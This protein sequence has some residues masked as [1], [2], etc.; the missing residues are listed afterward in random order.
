MVTP[1]LNPLE[2]F[3]AEGADAEWLAFLGGGVDFEPAPHSSGIGEGGLQ[4]LHSM[5]KTAF[6]D[7]VAGHC[8]SDKELTWA[9]SLIDEST[10]DEGIAK[11]AMD[12]ADEPQTV[13]DFVFGHAGR[14]IYPEDL[15]ELAKLAFI[16]ELHDICG[17]DAGLVKEALALVDDELF[18]VAVASGALGLEKVAFKIP[19]L[20]TGKAVMNV[21]RQM[22]GSAS[23]KIGN[24]LVASGSAAREGAIR[25][26]ERLQSAGKKMQL[27]PDDWVQ[28]ASGRVQQQRGAHRAASL[29]PRSTPLDKVTGRG[30][31]R[32]RLGRRMQR[33]GAG[34]KDLARARNPLTPAP[35][36]L[37]AQRTATEALNPKGVAARMAAAPKP[38]PTGQPSAEELKALVAAGGDGV[39]SVAAK[40][41]SAVAPGGALSAGEAASLESLT[42]D[43]AKAQ[44]AA[45]AKAEAD[46]AAKAQAA[47]AAKAEADAAAK[48][49]AA[50][51]A[52]AEADAAAKLKA[53]GGGEGSKGTAKGTWESA[54]EWFTNATPMQKLLVGGGGLVGAEAALD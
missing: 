9:L 16:H 6:V 23:S 53:A 48:A 28:R 49:Q 47:A 36:A 20:S 17:G 37:A 35:E 50:A 22:L 5:A 2:K 7:E 41:P 30:A 25:G 1:G 14:D 8:R 45:A 31:W 12:L 24:K 51:A 44:A 21:G 34:L 11:L 15:H 40:T 26:A 13:S 38:A 33:E 42:G 4:S 18:D 43:A 19:G 10:L 39:A 29:G 32:M 46:A 3:A 27:H 52:K 54:N